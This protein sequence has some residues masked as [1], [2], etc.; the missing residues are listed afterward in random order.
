M[1]IFAYE[2]QI[3]ADYSNTPYYLECLQ[4]IAQGRKSEDLQ[5]KVALEATSDKISRRDVRNAYRELILDA[6]ESYEDDTII[7][8]FNSRI[9]DAP[10]QEPEMRRALKVIGQDRES[11]KIQVVASQGNVNAHIDGNNIN[12]VTAV[13][14]Y[15]QA[16]SFLGAS[17]DTA[18]EFIPSMFALRVISVPLP[19]T[20]F[21]NSQL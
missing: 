6:R 21:W 19:S 14:N 13:T 4:G 3:S 18:D 2:Q 16:L 11:E 7:G 15:E 12:I 9:T 8:I 1:L 5:L 20:L 17:H 10:K